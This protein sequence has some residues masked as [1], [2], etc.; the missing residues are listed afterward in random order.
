MRQNVGMDIVGLGGMVLLRALEPLEGIDEMRAR[1]GRERLEELCS[2]PAKLTRALGITRAMNGLRV[3]NKDCPVEVM[4]GAF[5]GE[6]GLGPRVG[7][8]KSVELP[9]RF[10]EVGSGFLSR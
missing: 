5:T 10:F 4:V 9:L 3:G 8:T 7:I 1:R 2:G 6:I